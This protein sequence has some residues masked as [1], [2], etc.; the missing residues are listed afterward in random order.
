MDF[1]AYLLGREDGQT[2]M[3]DVRTAI[4]KRKERKIPL[5]ER[6][7]IYLRHFTALAGADAYPVFGTDLY[8]MDAAFHADM[9]AK[10]ARQQAVA[11]SLEALLSAPQEAIPSESP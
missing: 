4:A 9:Q 1:A 3:A 8:G 6:L 5:R 2:T 11:D 10:K 7:P